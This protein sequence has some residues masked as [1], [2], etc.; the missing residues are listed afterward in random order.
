MQLRTLIAPTV[1]A[2]LCVPALATAQ[3]ENAYRGTFSYVKGQ[4]GDQPIPA[5]DL[6]GSTVRV[7]DGKVVLVGADGE[8][9]FTISYTVDDS[10]ET[11]KVDMEIVKS[12]M[13]ETVGSKAK[14]LVKVDDQGQITLIYDYAEGAGY[15]EDF[16]PD[17]ATQHLFVLKKKAD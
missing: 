10:G 8:D 9:Q 15:P 1:A 2:L 3:E 6:E 12:I 7:E 4:R 5:Q 14:G 16:S 17:G 11:V 13:A